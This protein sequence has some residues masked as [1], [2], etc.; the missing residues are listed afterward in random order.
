MSGATAA[1]PMSSLRR[2]PRARLEEAH[3]RLDKVTAR[4]ARDA[5]PGPQLGDAA[6]AALAKGLSG[7]ALG[8]DPT[9]AVV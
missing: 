4:F 6:H 2:I 5:G 7:E 8:R 3:R 9:E 1:I